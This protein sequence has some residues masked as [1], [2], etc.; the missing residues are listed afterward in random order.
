MTQKP[1]QSRKSVEEVQNLDQM[2][3][4]FQ[5]LP[6]F[7]DTFIARVS[8]NSWNSDGVMAVWDFL[9]E[10]QSFWLEEPGKKSTGKGGW[11]RGGKGGLEDAEK[12]PEWRELKK[13]A[14]LLCMNLQKSRAYS[15]STNGSDRQIAQHRLWQFNRSWKDRTCNLSLNNWLPLKEEHHPSPR[16]IIGFSATKYKTHNVFIHFKSYTTS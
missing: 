16:I 8:G 3:V 1:N 6:L 2:V 10:I 15:C 4:R 12:I 9:I 14:L 13:E 7:F 11:G 5:F